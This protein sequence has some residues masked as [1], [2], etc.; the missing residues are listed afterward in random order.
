MIN[1]KQAV[2]ASVEFLTSIDNEAQ[3][4]LVEE[5]EYSDYQLG[6]KAWLIT[7]SFTHPQSQK[8][9]NLLSALAGDVRKYKIFKVDSDKGEVLS[10]KIRELDKAQ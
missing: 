10:M 9:N 5:V 2:A 6:T 1:V 4:V 3:D 7:L 8:K